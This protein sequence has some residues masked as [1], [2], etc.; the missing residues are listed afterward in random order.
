MDHIS[1]RIRQVQKNPEPRVMTTPQERSFRYTTFAIMFSV[2]RA[3][4]TVLSRTPLAARCMHASAGVQAAADPFNDP[5]VIEMRA[6]IQNHEGTKQAIIKLG[7]LM[8]A[9]GEW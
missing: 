4:R 8:Q 7:E 5:R 9:K 2:L 3:S 6:K 1:V